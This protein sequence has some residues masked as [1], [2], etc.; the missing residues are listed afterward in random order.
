MSNYF[1]DSS[2]QDLGKSNKRAAG[3][4]TCSLGHFLKFV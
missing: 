2:E 1:I 4:L 3:S